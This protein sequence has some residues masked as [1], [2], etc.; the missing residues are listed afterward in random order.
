MCQR[1]ER[2]LIYLSG[3]TL[4]V[5]IAILTRRARI[6]VKISNAKKRPDITKAVIVQT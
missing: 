5:A 4:S 2:V 3:I 6:H 1:S